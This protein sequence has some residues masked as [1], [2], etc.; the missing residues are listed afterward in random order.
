MSQRNRLVLAF[1]VA[2]IA[3]AAVYLVE[4]EDQAASIDDTAAARRSS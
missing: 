2:P 1:L 3:P 4:D